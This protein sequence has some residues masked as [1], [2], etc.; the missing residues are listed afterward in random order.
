MAGDLSAA[1]AQRQYT[2]AIKILTTEIDALRNKTSAAKIVSDLFYNKGYCRQQM[3]LWRK[4]AE[5]R[6]APFNML[7]LMS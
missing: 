2:A 6:T 1:A 3:K 7:V 5:V 4:A